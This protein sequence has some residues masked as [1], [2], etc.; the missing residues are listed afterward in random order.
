MYDSRSGRQH[1]RDD[2]DRRPSR[3]RSSPRTEARSRGGRSSREPLYAKAKSAPRPD[4][5]DEDVVDVDGPEEGADDVEDNQELDPNALFN[6]LFDEIQSLPG[7]IVM[8]SEDFIRVVRRLV[9]VG[10]SSVP[11]F[12]GQLAD[13]V[14]D[15]YSDVAYFP[16]DEAPL[17]TGPGVRVLL[18]RLCAEAENRRILSPTTALSGS[19]GSGTGDPVAT[20]AL[21]KM[22]KSMRFHKKKKNPDKD[23]S[24]CDSDDDVVPLDLA[25]F[26]SQYRSEKGEA[27]LFSSGWFVELQRMGRLRREA[28]ARKDPRVPHVASSSVDEWVPTWVGEAKSKSEKKHLRSQIQSDPSKSLANLLTLAN[29]FWLSHWAVGSVSL[30]AVFAHQLHLVQ[31]AQERSVAFAYTY[32]S[33]LKA[34]ISADIKAGVRFNLDQRISDKDVAVFSQVEIEQLR[35]QK[36]SVTPRDPRKGRADNPSPDEKPP[37]PGAKGKGKGKAK[38]EQSD[39]AMSEMV[40]FREDAQNKLVC[41]VKNCRFKHVDTTTR[42]GKS[43]YAAA[44]AAA[45]R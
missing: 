1:G 17:V 5:A 40:C 32:L 4:A 3:S 26:L 28:D 35:D 23:L 31:L 18:R 11:A 6:N 27:R 41:T 15:V 19:R 12:Q 38:G 44:K 37:R 2:H 21:H 7:E 29:T 42:E 30:P 33:R 34:R 20:Q 8:P 10:F 13:D 14:L 36:A 24:S 9:A 25:K 22:S 16:E 39:K 43:A 45:R